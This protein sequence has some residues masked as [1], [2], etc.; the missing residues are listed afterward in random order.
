MH[1]SFTL[2]YMVSFS[3]SINI[4]TSYL[5]ESEM[6]FYSPQPAQRD[7][8]P[9]LGFEYLP[10][11]GG[12]SSSSFSLSLGPK[13]ELSHCLPSAGMPHLVACGW[14]ECRGKPWGEG[15]TCRLPPL[16][17]PASPPLVPLPQYFL[18]WLQS[19]QLQP[20]PAWNYHCLSLDRPGPCCC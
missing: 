12:N 8:T 3:S 17:V 16:P 4:Y 15:G 14:R 19:L 5:L 20:G 9:H 13:P 18:F 7:K 10:G 1:A 11:A 2:K 6:R